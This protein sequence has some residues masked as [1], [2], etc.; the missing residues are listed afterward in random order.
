MCLA[1]QANEKALTCARIFSQLDTTVMQLRESDLIELKGTGQYSLEE[2]SFNQATRQQDIQHIK[3]Y[4][5]V[6]DGEVNNLPKEDLKDFPG[7]LQRRVS[8]WEQEKEHLQQEIGIKPAESNVSRGLVEAGRNLADRVRSGVQSTRSATTTGAR[9]VKDQAVKAGKLGFEG[10][11]SLVRGIVETGKKG[12]SSSAA[13]VTSGVTSLR[14]KME[15]F[16]KEDSEQTPK[17][18]D[19]TETAEAPKEETQLETTE[20]KTQVKLETAETGSTKISDSLDLPEQIIEALH[21]EG[22]HE[23]SELVSYGVKNHGFTSIPGVDKNT[24]EKIALK[25]ADHIVEKGSNLEKEDIVNMMLVNSSEAETTEAEAEVSSS[26]LVEAG[27][28]LADRVRSGVQ[29]TRSA[30]S[31]GASALSQ[32]ARS[33]AETA[34]QG[35]RSSVAA[36]TSGVNFLRERVG[37][38]EK[39]DS[40]Q[41]PTE[42]DQPTTT[43][44]PK[45]ET[46]TE[47]TE[48][49][50]QPKVDSEQPLAE[51]TQTE[52]K[53]APP[54][55]T[56]E[57]EAEVSS[58][59]LVEAGRN[60]ADRVRSGVQSTRSAVTTGASA[61]SQRARSS[62]ETARQGVRSSVAAVTSGVNFLRERVGRSEKEDS[63]QTPTE[64]DQPT[65]TEVPK[66]ETQT[67]TKEAPPKEIQTETQLETTEKTQTETTEVE[68]QPKV[69]SEQP[70]AEKT[71]TETKEAPPAETGES[72]ATKAIKKKKLKT[73]EVET[74]EKSETV[75]T[76][77]SDSVGLENLDIAEG[78][79]KILHN[80]GIHTV[81]EL[82]DY[83]RENSG[84]T[85]I[86]GI[87]KIWSERLSNHL[88]AHSVVQSLPLYTQYSGASL[89][90]LGL[91]EKTMR[92]LN[93]RGIR[94]V[95]E[96]ETYKREISGFASI[97][98][99][100]GETKGKE[101]ASKLEEYISREETTEAEA[102][103][104]PEAFVSSLGFS[105]KVKERLIRA[106]HHR[107]IHTASELRDYG[108]ANS[109]DFTSIPYIGESMSRE[110]ASKLADYESSGTPE[111][112]SASVLPTLN[113]EA[114]MDTIHYS[115]TIEEVLEHPNKG[116]GKGK[117]LLVELKSGN[118]NILGLNK[119][120]K[121]SSSVSLGDL[122]FSEKMIT[123]LHNEGIHTFYELMNYWMKNSGLTSITGIGLRTEGRISSMVVD[124]IDKAMYGY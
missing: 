19:Q 40:E 21:S 117:V 52:T 119:V 25:L 85:S 101:I 3:S 17:E 22:I 90:R 20:A 46:Q 14:E 100:V 43:E 106:L 12:V 67:E 6:I 39:E 93:L 66:E 92:T 13:A 98:Q 122:G 50:T 15:R 112:T 118:D 110:I 115:V 103:S 30:V 56:T 89:D 121:I 61:L 68:T 49:E 69:D 16:R 63:E 94:T 113:F 57:A 32:R 76:K 75:G 82:M 36:V 65:T 44:V 27:R 72:E 83:R 35:V 34:R 54:A 47:T 71:Q 108:V 7:R 28:N 31:T 23:V 59:R 96:L 48:V 97:A 86:P 64:K 104:F 73:E 42:K 11:Q 2:S 26:R 107:G 91:S 79:I 45:E 123:V 116:S 84:F 1:P 81:S 88:D 18:T 87:G 95:S 62:A 41:T 33:S 80:Q 70:L 60:L 4:I 111:Q 24:S 53:E 109:V 38:S 120:A 124:Y 58:S 37:R 114:I 105:E 55:E 8:H 74:Q 102:Q 9:S 10:S 5:D 51:K 29:G 77:S 99:S 78:I